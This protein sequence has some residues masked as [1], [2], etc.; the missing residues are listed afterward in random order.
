[1]G[2]KSV[3]F[4]LPE[5]M[6]EELDALVKS[7]EYTSR[8]DVFRDAFRDFLRNNPGKRLRIAIELYKDDEVSLMRAAEIADLN[9]EKFK[10][11]LAERGIKVKT[12]YDSQ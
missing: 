7:G 2:S 6:T 3:S 9:A 1:M 11:E 10:E 4:S 8:S 12:Y 5:I